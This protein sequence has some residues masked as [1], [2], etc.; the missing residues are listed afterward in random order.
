[1]KTEALVFWF[2]AVFFLVMSPVYWFVSGEVIGSVALGFTAVL[3]I[4]I[5]AFLQYEARHFDARPEDRK[6]ATIAESAGVYGF[7]PPKSIW[8]FW[9]ALVVTIIFL[10]PSVEQWWISVLGFGLGIW[11]CSGWVLEYY[12]G[13]YQH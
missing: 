5:A 10:G 11:A 4:M 12:R 3:G 7:F 2:I 6:D 8:P 1:M 13:D 9:C